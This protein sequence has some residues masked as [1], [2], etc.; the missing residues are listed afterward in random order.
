MSANSTIAQ[1]LYL[2]MSV[3]SILFQWLLFIYFCQQNITQY[4]LFTYVC[5]Q[6][7]FFNGCYLQMS[8]N[9]TFTQYFLFTYVCHKHNFSTVVTCIHICLSTAQLLN[10]LYLHITVISI[11]FQWLLFI[12]FCQHNN[13][14]ILSIYICLSLA[15]FFN[16]CYMY[17]HMSSNSIFTHFFY[18]H[19]SAISILFQRLLFTDVCQ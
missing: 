9:N 14:S 1:Y 19:M 2:H 15:Y 5:H 11:L 7:T 16:G 12:Y 10:I 3:I 18:L 4:F 6:H 13:P 17:S 8:A